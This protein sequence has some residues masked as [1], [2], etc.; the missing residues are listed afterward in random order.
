MAARFEPTKTGEYLVEY[1]VEG[2]YQ[3]ETIRYE[4][5]A[6]KWL[7]TQTPEF[8]KKHITSWYF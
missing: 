6:D 5:K 1:L 3:K 8:Y 7:G 2:K 4:K